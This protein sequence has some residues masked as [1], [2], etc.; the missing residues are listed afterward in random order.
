MKKIVVLVDRVGRSIDDSAFEL[1]T[2]AR[3]AAGA[4]VVGVLAGHD[5]ASYGAEL[6]RWF[7]EV[8]LVDDARL[9]VPDGDAWAAALA[10]LLRAEAADC[11]LAAH[12][13]HGLDYAPALSVRLDLALVSDCLSVDLS[14]PAVT[15][16]RPV[17][18]GKVHARVAVDPAAGGC[19]V[20]L[21]PGTVRAGACPERGGTVRHAALPAGFAPRRRFVETVAGDAGEVDITQAD[22]LVAVGRGIEDAESLDLV[23]DLA[24]ALGAEVA[25]SRPVVD[26][27]WLPKSRQVGTSGKS[28]KP[29]LYVALGISGSFQHLGGL[30]GDPFVVAVNKDPK[31]PIFSVA[32]V[33]IVGDLYEVV[34]ALTAKLQSLKG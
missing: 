8:V 32:D 11:V 22:R 26:K 30:K 34:P 27:Q 31:A 28:V 19:L 23:R 14:G 4:S 1:A 9:A 33:G 29:K 16:V 15:A 21:R 6:A 20:T 3:S 13:N 12:T 17:H 5:L 2:A 10:P 24:A 18:G 7:D 25:C